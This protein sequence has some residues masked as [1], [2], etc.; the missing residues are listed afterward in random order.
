VLALVWS[1]LEAA[2]I[3]LAFGFL[4]IYVINY[5]LEAKDSMC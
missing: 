5:S 4:F 3:R 2:D 1:M